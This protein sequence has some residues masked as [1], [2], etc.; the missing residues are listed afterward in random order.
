[1]IG[2]PLTPIFDG[3]TVV[4]AN[5]GLW[6]A[7]C[8]VCP[9]AEH[10]GAEPV[11]GYVGGLTLKRFVCSHCGSEAKPKWPRNRKQIETIL[12]DRR[13]RGNR[14]WVPGETLEQ[15]QAENELH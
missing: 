15:L 6:V 14:N 11:S 5:D 1:M 4:Y 7:E 12:A 2:S 13:L 3:T 9:S 10:Y 8:P